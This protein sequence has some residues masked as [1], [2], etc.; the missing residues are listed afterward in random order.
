[1]ASQLAFLL[2]C[3]PNGDRAAGREVVADH[4][5]GK[6]VA[7]LFGADL[8]PD[9]VF[10]VATGPSRPLQLSLRGSGGERLDAVSASKRRASS[11]LAAATPP[12]A[13]RS[14]LLT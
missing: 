10:Q 8:V 12:D 1:M 4:V 7:A 2:P 3:V 11:L 14:L 13:L 5:R 9:L 6:N